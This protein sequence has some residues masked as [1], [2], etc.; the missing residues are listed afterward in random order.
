MDEFG[1]QL[2][3]QE[4]LLVSAVIMLALL[5]GKKIKRSLWKKG[6]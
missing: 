5:F 2:T 4:K 1:L 3:P 6:K